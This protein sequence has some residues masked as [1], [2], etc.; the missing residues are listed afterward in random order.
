[1]R[2]GAYAISTATTSIKPA[3]VKVGAPRP[4]AQNELLL[5]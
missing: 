2:E 3:A 1:M 4:S 5:P